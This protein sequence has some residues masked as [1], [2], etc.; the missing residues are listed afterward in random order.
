VA[1]II[2]P[3]PI[4]LD[5]KYH[6]DSMQWLK[7]CAAE[8]IL[9]DELQPLKSRLL[10]GFGLAHHNLSIG[11]Y[12]HCLIFCYA[13]EYGQK[14]RLEDPDSPVERSQAVVAGYE[15]CGLKHGECEMC[16]LEYRPLAMR[17]ALKVCCG[18]HHGSAIQ[19]PHRLHSQVCG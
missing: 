12:L 4:H 9:K 6:S 14:K 17:Q 15:L 5:I 8:C 16:E 13:I 3:V 2:L 11:A 7:R 19:G 1:K 10:Q 18:R